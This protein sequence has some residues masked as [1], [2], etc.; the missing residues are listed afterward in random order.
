MEKAA[1]LMLG[2]LLSWAWY[3][4]RRRIERQGTSEVIDRN[5]R[6]LALKGALE[7][8]H[9]DLDELRQFEARL[10]G[11]A[12]T[13]VRIADHYVTQAETV[14]R[15]SNDDTLS[16]DAM[17]QQALAGFRDADARLARLLVHV[18]RALDGTSV[19]AFEDAQRAWLLFRD[20]Y[21]QFVAQSYGSGAV[22]PLIRA[23]TLESVTCAWIS[24]LETQLG[25]D[26]APWTRV[27]MS[28]DA[29]PI[30]V[31]AECAPWTINHPNSATSSAPPG[32]RSG[33]HATR[34]STVHARHAFSSRT[35]APRAASSILGPTART[36]PWHS[37]WRWTR[38]RATSIAAARTRSPPTRWHDCMPM[39]PS[40]AVSI[41][42]W[43]RRCGCFSTCRSSIPKCWPTRTARSR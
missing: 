3:F 27:A 8:S 43:T 10:I 26:S 18:R 7:S 36:A 22:R 42:R 4:V 14:A 24:E 39:P 15:Q 35:C 1:Y 17:G 29:I 33:S 34:T 25:D 40:R 16:Q 19:G 28:D 5:T 2:A 11:K 23:V 20:R 37:C 30:T 12:Q 41:G 38:F 31:S 21:A 9:T 13:A 6:L 32:P